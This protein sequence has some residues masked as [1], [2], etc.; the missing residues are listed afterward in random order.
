MTFRST[1]GRSLVASG[2]GSGKQSRCRLRCCA[3]WRARQLLVC[4]QGQRRQQC[5]LPPLQSAGQSLQRL[6]T[7]SVSPLAIAACLASQPLVWPPSCNSHWLQQCRW[8]GRAPLEHRDDSS[9]ACSAPAT[10]ISP[11]SCL[12]SRLQRVQSQHCKHP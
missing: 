11:Y 4:S 5:L 6:K 2:R 7:T 12:L 9:S 8:P 10:G 1:F 3:A